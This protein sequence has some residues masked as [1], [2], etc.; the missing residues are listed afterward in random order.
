VNLAQAIHE[1][2]EQRVLLFEGK[3]FFGHIDV[4]LNIRTHNTLI[5]L[6][7]HANNLDEG[8]IHDVVVEHASGIHVLLG[9]S[10]IQVAHGLRPDDL[11]SVMVGLQRFF[12]FVVIDAGS[13][14]S[15]NTVTLM[16]ASDRIMVVGTPDLASLRDVSRFIQISQS[17]SYPSEKILVVLN[18]EGQLGG[19]KTKDIESTLKRQ[20]FAKIPDD[21][22]NVQ[23]SLNRGVPLQVKYP[24]SLT[25]KAIKKLSKDLIEMQV[26]EQLRMPVNQVSRGNQMEALLVSSQFG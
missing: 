10:N 6:I 13:S 15:E 19:V 20:V 22:Q 14:L 2:S 21:G 8:L 18:R 3:Q 25:A 11:Y 5:D 4:L 12:D 24:R 1:E 9:P 26:V 16:D 7:P 17:L 23:R